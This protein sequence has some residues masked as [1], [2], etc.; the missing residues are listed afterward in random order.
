MDRQYIASQGSILGGNMNQQQANLERQQ[1]ISEKLSHSSTPN[2]IQTRS[3]E[4]LH[5]AIRQITQRESEMRARIIDLAAR[6]GYHQP[7]Q[8]SAKTAPAPVPNGCFEAIGDTLRTLVALQ[9][10]N[11]HFMGQIERHI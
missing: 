5:E 2:A 1:M 4:Q 11:S 8:D 3:V 10:D 6:L 9:D 7:S